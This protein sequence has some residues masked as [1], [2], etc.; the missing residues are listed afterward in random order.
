MPT[1]FSIVRAFRP[2]N[3]VL[4]FGI[5]WSVR[6]GILGHDFPLNPPEKNA[7]FIYA[8]SIL[9]CMVWGYLINDWND[10]QTDRINKPGKNLFDGPFR[11]TGIVLTVVALVGSLVLPMLLW[12][13]AS[14]SLHAFWLNA[15]AAFL[16][17]L[18]AFR[19]KSSVF[20]GNGLIALLGFLLVAAPLV[21]VQTIHQ[22]ASTTLHR[23]IFFAA[24]SFWITLIREMVKDAEDAEG[25]ALSGLQTS[26]TVKGKYFTL[27]IAAR[28][29]LTAA[30]FLLLLSVM[31][32]TDHKQL[33]RGLSYIALSVI[34]S[35][36]G[37]FIPRAETKAQIARCSLFLKAWMAGGIL[38]MWI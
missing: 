1:V 20:W 6:S 3:L 25:D 23:L 9:L 29:C 38:C 28:L 37:F 31:E 5:L 36:V 35:L 2:L 7:F 4:A 12:I 27:T 26:A 34:G 24:F 33:L 10:V 17:G 15:A 30:V 18:Y 8:S 21:T 19:M 13:N 32:F 11:K 16:L 14:V 22:I